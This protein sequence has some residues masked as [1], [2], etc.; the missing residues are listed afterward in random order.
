MKNLFLISAIC[1]G[2][3][4]TSCNVGVKKDLVSGLNISNDGL[5]LEDAYLSVNEKKIKDAVPY[6]STVT[7]TV[8]G[9]DGF[10]QKSG[11][12]F[13]D[14]SILV[15]NKAGETVASLGG[16]FDEFAS[17]GLDAAEVKK[18]LTLSLTCQSPIKMNE[19]YLCEFALKDRNGKGQIKVSNTLKMQAVEG[20]NYKPNG[21][22]ADGIFYSRNNETSSLNEN[23]LS[24]G[25][26]LNAYFTGLKGFKE[27]NGKVWI[28]ASVSMQD[29]SGNSLIEVKDLF[30]AYDSTGIPVEDAAKL[31]TL[32]LKTGDKVAAG[33]D[34]KA[35]FSLKDKKGSA[36]LSNEFSFK[37]R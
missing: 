28:D 21:L 11:K 12:V 33:K 7:L 22:T 1:S 34:Y 35:V 5:S 37:V 23:T 18:G 29:P 36:A 2:L 25:D 8:T 17:T 20:T 24:G 15:K 9:I 32:T 27:E 14:A 31:I 26:E 19:E 30:A 13:P 4:L 16:L 10:T 6:G 3:L